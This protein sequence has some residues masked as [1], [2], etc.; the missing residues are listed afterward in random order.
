MT[1]TMKTLNNCK[2][3]RAA[4]ADLLLDPAYAAAHADVAGHLAAC[5]ECSA[6]LESLRAT[7]NLMN[8]WTAP[9]PS[10]YFDTRLQVRL[11]EA[12]EQG[13]EGFWERLRSRLLFNTGRQFRPAMVG[14]LAFL[15]LI[16]GGAGVVLR[17]TPAPHPTAA[18][19]TIDDLKVLD[20]NAQAE[21]QMDQ[22][23]DDGSAGSSDDGG[24]PPTS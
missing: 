3:C 8:E 10:P 1:T 19:A 2:M 13:P 12:I 17:P 21:Q 5:A 23:L 4:L 15:M 9:E 18:S 24:A 20:N 22:L 14:A 11:R 7:M 16:G 6:E